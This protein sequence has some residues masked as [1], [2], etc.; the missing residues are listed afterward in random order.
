VTSLESASCE[1]RPGKTGRPVALP[2]P[3]WQRDRRCAPVIAAEV[4]YD[5]LEVIGPFGPHVTSA[6]ADNLFGA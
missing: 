6:A 3:G 4:P 2:W 1:V 5:T